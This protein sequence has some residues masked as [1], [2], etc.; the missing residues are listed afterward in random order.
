MPIKHQESPPATASFFDTITNDSNPIN[1]SSGAQQFFT[2]PSAPSPFQEVPEM[3]QQ[4]HFSDISMTLP[5]IPEQQINYFQQQQQPPPPPS[6]NDDKINDY[7]MQISQ[8]KSEVEFHRMTA[9]NLQKNVDELNRF[10]QQEQHQTEAIKLLVKEKTHLADAFQK[11]ENII[12][13]LKGETEELHNRLNLSRHRVKQLESSAGTGQPNIIPEID[14]RKIEELVEERMKDVKKSLEANE[15]EKNELK[16]LLHQKR[17]EMENLQRNYDHLSNELHL[18]SIKIAQLSDGVQP[19]GD[20][21]A[22]QSHVAALTQDSAIKQQQM[23]E[24]NQVIDQLNRE[25][26]ASETQYQNYVSA[27]TAEMDLLKESSIELS[28]ENNSLVKREQE[29]LKHVSDLERQIQQQINKQKIY[30]EN[31]TTGNVGVTAAI[32]S[33]HEVQV[34]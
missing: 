10:R 3:I 13:T 32:D 9:T 1:V 28:S 24:L 16:I 33:S 19:E 29:L 34:N 27:M 2:T 7:Q 18:Q 11:S 31:S 8:L 4:T 26:E 22:H 20:H 21:S 15:S 6:Q 12:A 25:K 23:N 30:A 14:T 5:S 17:I